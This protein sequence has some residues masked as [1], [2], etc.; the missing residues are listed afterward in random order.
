MLDN[1]EYKKRSEFKKKKYEE[2][3]IEFISLSPKDLEDRNRLD[4]NF[5]QK[6]LNLI[7]DREG[8]NLEW[9]K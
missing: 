9:R 1:E 5:T 3:G 8:N 7:R 2:N 4:W 6:L